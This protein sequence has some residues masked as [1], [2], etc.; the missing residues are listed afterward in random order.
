VWILTCTECCE[1]VNL[2]FVKLYYVSPI[3]I[4]LVI[5]PISNDL[6]WVNSTTPEQTREQLEG[7]L[8]KDRWG[9]VNWLWVGFGQ[10]VQQQKEKMLRKILGCSS[11]REGLL[12]V[13]RLRLDITKEAS[14]FGLEEEVKRVMKEKKDD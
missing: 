11:P 1:S 2:Y 4:P 13:K 7:W 3:L 14:R 10:E 9:K 5:Y 12:L 6:K 8:P